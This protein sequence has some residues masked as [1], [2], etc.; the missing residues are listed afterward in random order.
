MSLLQINNLQN[1]ITTLIEDNISGIN[2]NLNRKIDTVN[3]LT[4]GNKY[5][6]YSTSVNKLNVNATSLATTIASL[7]TKYNTIVEGAPDVLNTPKELANALGDDANYAANLLTLL[8]KNNNGRYHE[9]QYI[10]KRPTTD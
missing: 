9:D 10:H 6:S 4:T 7:D 1:Q 8:E 2:N 3:D 5:I